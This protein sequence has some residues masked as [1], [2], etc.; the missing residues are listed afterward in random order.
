[1]AKLAGKWLKI[2]LDNDAG[3]PCDISTYVESIDLP[4]E[5]DELDVTGFLD[6]SKNSIPGMPGF[7]IELACSFSVD[8]TVGTHTVLSDIVGTGSAHTLTAQL[9][10]NTTPTTGDPE[11]EG[12][13]WCPKY[14]VSAT[15]TGKVAVT[16]SLRVYGSVAPGWGL[17]S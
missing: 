6:G 13:F 4:T 2:Y 8:A 16:S 12:E 9:G 7:N 1:M 3:L 15:P 11:F 14:G 17:V 10:Q 5:F